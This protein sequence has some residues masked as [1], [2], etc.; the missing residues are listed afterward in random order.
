[1]APSTNK[2]CNG[3]RA[4]PR[5]PTDAG[6]TL[7]EVLVAVAVIAIALTALIHSSAENTVNA[8]YLRDKTFAHWVAMNKLAELRA[9]SAWGTGEQKGSSPMGG[10]ARTPRKWP[11]QVKISKT[12]NTNIE[13]VE[14]TVYNP[15]NDKV[16]LDRIVG[17]LGNPSMSSTTGAGAQNP[18][19]QSGGGGD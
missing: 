15:E 3:S 12:P 9:Q 2:P 4:G 18:G 19:L 17:F 13:Q 14:I 6:F 16:R 7:M 10:T 5:I 1:M 8:A 11:W